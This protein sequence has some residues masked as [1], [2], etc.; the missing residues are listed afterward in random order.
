[1]GLE[2]PVVINELGGKDAFWI[3]SAKDSS[4]TH[5]KLSM[6]SLRIFFWE[7]NRTYIVME[8]QKKP[9]QKYQII[10]LSHRGFIPF[11]L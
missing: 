8:K 7:N 10:F 5:D 6:E 4:Y 3:N 2:E 9:K 1:M 11:E